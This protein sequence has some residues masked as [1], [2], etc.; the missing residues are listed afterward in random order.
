MCRTIMMNMPVHDQVRVIDKLN[1]VDTDVV[2]RRPG[3]VPVIG[4]NRM[5]PGE[6]DVPALSFC[7][8][9]CLGCH[10]DADSLWVAIMWP[11]LQEWKSRALDFSLVSKA[12]NLLA[13]SVSRLPR[14]RSKQWQHLPPQGQCLP[15]AAGWLGL[16]QLAECCANRFETTPTMATK[17]QLHPGEGTKE[18]DRKGEI[19]PLDL[20][21]E[22]RLPS[23]FTVTGIEHGGVFTLQRA[24]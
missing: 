23:K 4:M 9:G 15:E 20:L 21:E 17:G 13:G 16:C 7:S 18:V 22:D 2:T 8:S 1:P 5:D 12:Y 24:S 19:T 10:V 11:T 14:S 6:R 3:L